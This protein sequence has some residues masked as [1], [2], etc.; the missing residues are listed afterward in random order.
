MQVPSSVAVRSRHQQA[1]PLPGHPVWCKTDHLGQ[2]VGGGKVY[3]SGF[4]EATLIFFK[5]GGEWT[6]AGGG[7]NA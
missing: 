5:R 2:V 1:P 6:I 7:N 4:Q 3:N